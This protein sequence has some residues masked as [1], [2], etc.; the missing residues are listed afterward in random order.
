MSLLKIKTDLKPTEKN[1][2]EK[3]IVEESNEHIA[4]YVHAFYNHW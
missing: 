3:E 2:R 4:I 1:C